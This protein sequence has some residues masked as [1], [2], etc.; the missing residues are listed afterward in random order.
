MVLSDSAASWLQSLGRGKEEE[1][2]EGGEE[3]PEPHTRCFG[4]APLTV[5][6]KP[7]RR[8]LSPKLLVCLSAFL[9]GVGPAGWL[10]A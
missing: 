2:A 1:D 3:K 6:A 4:T 5:T 8:Q 9:L 10:P 7:C